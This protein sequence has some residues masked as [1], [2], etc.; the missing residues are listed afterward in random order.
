MAGVCA[1][2]GWAKPLSPVSGRRNASWEQHLTHTDTQNYKAEV[3]GY[4]NIMI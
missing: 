4:D 1:L 2:R 3:S